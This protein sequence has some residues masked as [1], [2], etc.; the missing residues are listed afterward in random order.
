M[1]DLKNIKSSIKQFFC[2]Y[3]ENTLNL[4]VITS[5]AQSLI[6]IAALSLFL[7][8][9]A[10]AAVV[11]CIGASF[12]V[13]PGTRDKI[14]SHKGSFILLIFTLI[15]ATVAL[16][17]GNWTGLIRTGIFAMM[18]VIYLVARSLNSKKFFEK[19]LTFLVMGGT[20][21]AVVSSIEFY[22]NL[23]DAKYRCKSFF[24]NP[25]FFGI[26]MV[27]VIFI[28]AYKF[29][30]DSKGKWVY[31][32]FALINALGL[33]FSGSMSLWLVL[34]IGIFLLLLLNHKY[35][36]VALMLGVVAVAIV[37]I[38]AV[39]SLIPRLKELSLTF[40]NRVTI[41]DFAI[42]H[43]KETPVF[44]RG[45]Y[46]YKFLYNLYSP[47]DPTIYKASLSHNIIL[48]S[49]LCH[50]IVG[51]GLIFYYI[52]IFFKGVADCREKLK[53]KSESYAIS[54]F[55]VA[56]AVTLFFYGLIDTTII[57]VQT[58]MIVLFIASGIGTEERKIKQLEESERRKEE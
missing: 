21:S 38:I 37:A 13:L 10:T 7:P 52:Y 12:C 23:G 57:F 55:I 26:A 31:F 46:T 45:F 56:V 24:T 17:H 35:K 42:K 47:N 49:L 44:G 2:F 36:L 34:V 8:Y 51:T 41:W 50:G 39:P 30:M 27:L 40:S 1:I 6:L 48:D 5:M 9:P 4:N 54:T 33:I 16:C 28:C 22:N 32:T 29:I 18:I 53:A 25:N 15:T 14:F 58:G 19:L 11:S 43:F 20:F 3:E